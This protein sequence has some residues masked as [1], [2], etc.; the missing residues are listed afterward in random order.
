M[1]FYGDLQ[2]VSVAELLRWVE[3]GAKNGTLEVERD[4]IVKRLTF[5][6]GR[7]ISCSSNDPAT[8]MGQFL[9]SRG[10]ITQQLLGEALHQQEHCSRTLGEILKSMEAI[11]ETEI[12]QFMEAKIGEAIY[13]LFDAE[14]GVFRFETDSIADPYAVEVDLPIHEVLERG[15]QRSAPAV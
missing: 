2:T 14:D 5:S 4:K 13:G 7:V 3:A 15:R 12:G 9:L 11:T 8:L 10:A 6:E 1:G